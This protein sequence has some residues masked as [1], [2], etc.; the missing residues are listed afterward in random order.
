VL[1]EPRDFT[2]HRGNQ[3][4]SGNEMRLDVV[5]HVERRHALR[6]ATV[7]HRRTGVAINRLVSGEKDDT[8]FL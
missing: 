1:L 8:A 5:A 3:R 6:S 7:S 4:R 2:D